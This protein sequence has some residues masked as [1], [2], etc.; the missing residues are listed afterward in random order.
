[1]ALSGTVFEL[2]DIEWYHDLEIWVRGH[3]GSFKM[4]PFES[5]GAVSYSPSIVTNA[6]SC[7]SSEIKP[8]IGCK[9]WLFH[10][11]LHS[12]PPLG[13][14]PSEYCH[15]V[16]FWQ[17]GVTDAFHSSPFLV[18]H[19]SYT[20]NF[21]AKY[22]DVKSKKYAKKYAGKYAQYYKNMRVKI[23]GIT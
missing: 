20:R 16:W 21:F 4:V 5:L 10:A 12:V 2:F 9:S 1:M 8:D 13:G 3:S 6:L 11:P 19:V 17:T 7:I 22:A 14:S 18:R 15:P 23:C